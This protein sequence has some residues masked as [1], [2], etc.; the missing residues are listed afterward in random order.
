MGRRAVLQ[1][2]DRL[3]KQ[4]NLE[5]QVGDLLLGKRK[6]NDLKVTAA[7][8]ERNETE[9]GII[10][11][12][13]FENASNFFLNGLDMSNSE[14]IESETLNNVQLKAKVISSKK[15]DLIETNTENKSE[16]DI[17]RSSEE[18]NYCP[19]LSNLKSLPTTIP[20][21]FELNMN[22]L[23]PTMHLLW[24]HS[25]IISIPSIIILRNAKQFIFNGADLMAGGIIFESTR[26]ITNIRK[27][28]IWTIK[29][30][31]DDYPIAIGVSLVD[32]DDI[33][34][35]IIRKGKVLKVIH[36]CND[37]LSLEG[38]MD[39]NEK[40][41]FN[42]EK[43]TKLNND[44]QKL[45]S[46]VTKEFQN[47]SLERNECLV[48]EKNQGSLEKYT[49][50]FQV[51][52]NELISSSKQFEYVISQNNC[53][54]QPEELSQDAYD[55]LLETSL[56]KVISEY[57][58]NKN[59]LPVDTSAIW[60]KISRLC[61]HNFGI[62]V[63]IKK[64]SF[65]K[66]QKFFQYYSKKNIL[67]IKQGRGGALNVV[68]INYE[69]IKK[70]ENSLD[71]KISLKLPP[72]KK[73][74]FSGG[75]NTLSKISNSHIEVVLLYQPEQNFLPI[76]DY[77]NS[78]E[79][80]H[81]GRVLKIKTS[82]GEKEQTFISVADAKTALEY[83][84]NSN[85][86]KTSDPNSN[87]AGRLSNIKLD[88]VLLSLFNKYL[89]D[90]SINSQNKVIPISLAYREIQNFL[91]VFHYI[92]N[93]G[94]PDSEN[95]PNIYKGPCKTVEIYTESRMGTRKHVTI[96]SPFISHFNLDPQEVAE[97]CQKKFACSATVSQIKKYPSNNNL[98]IIIQG[99]VVSQLST[100]LNSRW[101]IPKSYIKQC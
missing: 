38:N 37:F 89:G 63:D 69:E 94:D 101:G 79:M 78:K 55:F 80:N 17:S 49:N 39:F 82:R 67:L 33:S 90:K 14:V 22:R 58:S 64:S 43:E 21:L 3:I 99:N 61:L 32:W 46:E 13:E 30:I 4:F 76:V 8:F 71:N 23:F 54:K 51:P 36:H 31:G 97:S 18:C 45:T 59:L 81:L 65:I 26:N 10:Y 73:K 25:S 72:I 48:L 34:N 52:E 9:R 83:Y 77:Y 86:L 84:I 100:F 28:Q 29:C 19:N 41:N 7:K 6:K 56:L 1:L 53:E 95:R 11:R 85:N 47:I 60:D 15:S 5:S 66:V 27:D 16:K 68:D 12:M 74:S 40:K 98:G 70:I 91:K 96:I 92:R 57:S 93:E 42:E 35:Q 50:E 87:S 20:W 2:R 44:E 24:I 88:E 62:Q 75:E